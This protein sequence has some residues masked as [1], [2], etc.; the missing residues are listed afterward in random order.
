[1]QVVHSPPKGS[2]PQA[3]QR[4]ALSRLGPGPSRRRAIPRFRPCFKLVERE[5]EQNRALDYLGQRAVQRRRDR[6][7]DGRIVE[8]RAVRF[9]RGRIAAEIH[10]ARLGLLRCWDTG[11]EEKYAACVRTGRRY[12]ELR[13]AMG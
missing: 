6:D 10:A 12:Y 13:S 7:Q 1:M 11:E 3:R 5:I 9:P 2:R 4:S 8:V